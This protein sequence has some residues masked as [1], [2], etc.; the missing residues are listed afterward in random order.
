MAD[1][2]DTKFTKLFVGGIPYHTEDETMKEYFLQFDDIV[3]AVIIRE[4]NS[5]RSKGY[6]FV[7]MAT[8]EGAKRACVNKRPVIDGRRANVDLAYLGAKPKNPKAAPQQEGTVSPKCPSVPSSPTIS[9]QSGPIERGSEWVVEEQYPTYSTSPSF[10]GNFTY[11][12]TYSSAHTAP[13]QTM[14][15][16]PVGLKPASISGVQTASP[17]QS[18]MNAVSYYIQSY[19]LPGCNKDSFDPKY[20]DHQTGFNLVTYLPHGGPVATPPES[21]PVNAQCQPQFAQ[22]PPHPTKVIPSPR[23]VYTVPVWYIE[24]GKITCGQVSMD[25]GST[26]SQPP[27]I[28]AGM[29]AN[30]NSVGIQAGK[31]YP[32]PIVYY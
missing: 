9:E 3:E 6:G 5:Q 20:R 26:Y 4:R 17:N 15:M 24:Q 1:D 25:P 27:L 11:D 10:S 16:S 23:Y 31:L 18:P 19:S 29:A 2:D 30:T 8:K 22:T 28:T 7:T 14:I 12:F 32:T 13:A 21:L